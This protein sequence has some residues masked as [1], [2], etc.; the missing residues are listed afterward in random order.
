MAEDTGTGLGTP[1]RAEEVVTVRERVL[2]T[3]R[4]RLVT[5]HREFGEAPDVDALLRDLA[6]LHP[7]VIRQPFG[8]A[9]QVL[10]ML[11]RENFS[12]AQIS[13]TIGTDPAIA[14]ALLNH[15]NSDWY[16]ED[17]APPLAS[18]V[19]AARRV[20]A[21]GVHAAVMSV[22][23][24]GGCVRPG[25][26]L[27]AIARMVWDHMVRVAP[28]ARELAYGLGGDPDSA[29]TLGLCHDA[30]KLLLFERIAEVRRELRRDLTFPRGF[31]SSALRS[32]HEP[33]GGLAAFAWGMPPEWAAAIASHHRTEPETGRAPLT[34][35]V[36]VAERLDLMVHAERDVDLKRLWADGSISV[37]F[38]TLDRLWEEARQGAVVRE[39]DARQEERRQETG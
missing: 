27:D 35:A 7:G 30:G 2:K 12:W 3:F 17:G 39:L 10:D 6:A 4:D 19:A 28:M 14:Q 24:E 8:V 15:A 26:G 38:E 5:L 18:L 13:R 31:L 37:P 9:Q 20:G 36:F 22:L 16:D 1:A 29:F 25:A 32:V 21:R 11:N 33:L 23:L 34:E